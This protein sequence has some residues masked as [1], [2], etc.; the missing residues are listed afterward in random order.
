MK[1]LSQH[2]NTKQLIRSDF[3]IEKV[4]DLG[5][6]R[7]DTL[8]IELF[9][10]LSYG[11]FLIPPVNRKFHAFCVGLPRSGT[12]SLAYLFSSSYSAEHES[13]KQLTV[14]NIL[15]WVNGR[16]SNSKMRSILKSRDK[17]LKLELESSNFLHYAIEILVDLFPKA[18]FILTIREPISWLAS[19]INQHYSIRNYS[20]RQVIFWRKL[21]E[22]SYGFYGRNYIHKNL[23]DI[24]YVYPISNY[25][26][27][28]KNH[29]SMVLD[30]VPEDRLLIVDTFDIRDM[31][32]D[33]SSFVGA[34]TNS[35]NKSK[36]WSGR[37][38]SSLE[39]YDLVEKE[40]VLLQIEDQC[41]DFIHEKVPFILKYLSFSQ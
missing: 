28:W 41:G 36:Y 19:I 20:G 30:N 40:Q 23:A 32:C 18:K 15:D 25:L 9:N 14:A 29:I 5:I 27:Y 17:Y 34:D 3:N 21:Q 16:H 8:L 11:H 37:R 22:H 6:T 26:S 38:K 12:H 13:L 10:L 2:Q 31:L 7:K 35:F 33:I 4:G 24:P 39:L 1:E